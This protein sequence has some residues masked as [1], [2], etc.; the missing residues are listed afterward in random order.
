MGTPICAFSG[1]SMPAE[2]TIFAREMIEEYE[3]T[4]SYMRGLVNTK[5][6]VEAKTFTWTLSGK[7]GMAEERGANGEFVPGDDIQDQISVQLKEYGSYRR[8]M[9]FNIYTSPVDDRK[10][11]QRKNLTE[12]NRLTD[13][14]I[15]D[16]LATATQ[17]PMGATASV[18][19]L[20]AY[21]SLRNRL[22]TNVVSAHSRTFLV[23]PAL[24]N[25]TLAIKEFASRDY[26]T[27]E[28][29]MKP[30]MEQG[31]M[32]NG[33]LFLMHPG[34]PGVGTNSA[35]CYMFQKEAL[36][37]AMV[38]GEANVK[39]GHNEEQ[40]YFWSNAISM[41]G[42]KLLL[43]EGVAVYNHDDSIAF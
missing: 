11:Q 29:F 17:Y 5:G 4:K 20:A 1:H 22:D 21:Q 24:F 28:P 38:M 30:L 42:A 40:D 12:T 8:K 19:S 3:V 7:A 2:Q 13:K 32:F 34:L 18:F 23:T 25:R 36:G 39:S 43:P 27:D 31:R 37:H 6:K 16:Q 41:Q 33:T 35:K 10:E 14:L 15:I 26:V 9:G